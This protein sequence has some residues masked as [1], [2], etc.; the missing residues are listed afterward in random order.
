MGQLHGPLDAE[1]TAK[2][3][4]RQLADVVTGQLQ[5]ALAPNSGLGIVRERRQAIQFLKNTQENLGALDTLEA[6]EVLVVLVKAVR[7]A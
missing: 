1:S 6:A 3:S 5:G 2:R 7:F 4:H